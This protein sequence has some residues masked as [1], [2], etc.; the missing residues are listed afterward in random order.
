MRSMSPLISAASTL[1]MIECKSSAVTVSTADDAEPAEAQ[2][3][4]PGTANDPPTM[5]WTTDPNPVKPGRSC[6]PRAQPSSQ[7]TTT[8]PRAAE[9]QPKKRER[10]V[11]EAHGDLWPARSAQQPAA[12]PPT[13][14]PASAPPI[15]PHSAA[16]SELSWWYPAMA[17]AIAPPTAPPTAPVTHPPGGRPKSPAL[18]PVTAPL[19]A[20]DSAPMNASHHPEPGRMACHDGIIA[21]VSVKVPVSRAVRGRVLPNETTNLRIV[22]PSAYCIE[23][24]ACR[25]LPASKEE[26]LPNPLCSRRIAEPLVQ[27]DSHRGTVGNHPLAHRSREVVRVNLNPRCILPRQQRIHPRTVQP[28]VRQR[29]R[30]PVRSVPIH[31][32]R[33]RVCCKRPAPIHPVHIRRHP[34]LRYLLRRRRLRQIVQHKREPLRLRPQRPIRILIERYPPIKSVITG[35]I[36]VPWGHLGS[37]PAQTTRRQRGPASRCSAQA[38]GAVWMRARPGRTCA[39]T[40]SQAKIQA[41]GSG[42]R[43]PGYDRFVCCANFDQPAKGQGRG[44]SNLRGRSSTSMGFEPGV[45][46]GRPC[47]PPG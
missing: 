6:Y 37:G 19:A 25:P 9:A 46:T 30:D 35:M 5:Q 14:L 39:P 27:I 13:V 45:I 40:R 44:P 4:P 41:P 8:S 17:P 2:A 15:P 43:L 11:S 33:H 47:G 22:V 3:K 20:P 29:A 42:A 26:P 31:K 36:L 18:Q 10:Q 1:S 32:V 34:A 23:S 28:T 21:Y 7:L 38:T 24:R 12:T 16:S